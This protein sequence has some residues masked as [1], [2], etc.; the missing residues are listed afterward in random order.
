V[1][2]MRMYSVLYRIRAKLDPMVVERRTC[3]T[4]SCRVSMEGM[5][6]RRNVGPLRALLGVTGPGE[7]G[8]AACPTPHSET[9]GVSS[10]VMEAAAISAVSTTERPRTSRQQP[11]GY[12]TF[13][14]E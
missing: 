12:Y 7:P 13:E 1:I 9:A 5:K 10:G 14:Q 11:K 4:R 3:I 8:L 2:Q 6:I